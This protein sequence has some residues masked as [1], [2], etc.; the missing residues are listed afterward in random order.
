MLDECMTQKASRLVVQGLQLYK[1]PIHG[2]FPEDY[3]GFKGALDIDWT[4]QLQAEGDWSVITTDIGRQRG[5]QARLKG[6]PLHLILPAR[7]ITGIF[8]SGKMAQR[9][10]FE[11]ARCIFY[12][13]HEIV[14]AIER[15][16]PGT[17]FKIRPA[18]NGYSMSPWPF[19][20]RLP[21]FQDPTDLLPTE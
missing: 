13:I 1:P 12:L 4:K 11:K 14:A 17:R 5:N 7:N 20:E 3:F 9:G 2:E 16:A 21:E 8:L 6:P 18:G 10:G 15:S 19:T